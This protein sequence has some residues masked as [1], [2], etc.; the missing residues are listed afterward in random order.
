[1]KH[2]LDYQGMAIK[3]SEVIQNFSFSEG[4]LHRK[5]K[6]GEE[7]DLLSGFG[8]RK[9]YLGKERTICEKK[10]SFQLNRR[11]KRNEKLLLFM[12]SPFEFQ[13]WFWHGNFK[14]KVKV[15]LNDE[16]FSEIVIEPGENIIELDLG[17]VKVASRKKG[18]RI[19]LKFTY[20]QPFPFARL[21]K[22][23]VLLDRIE[24][25]TD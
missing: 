8:P 16:S 1:V 22:T 13:K 25:K 20:A 6:K 14:Q 11:L 2:Y 15:F 21:W 17:S 23:S 10:V 19:A 3:D 7:I 24:I 12:Y 9:G 4:I 5:R 18:S